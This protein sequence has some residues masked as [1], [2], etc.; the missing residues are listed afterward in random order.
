MRFYPVFLVSCLAFAPLCLGQ[1]RSPSP[2]PAATTS[3]AAAEA[4]K[5]VVHQLNNAFAR[6]FESVAP[7]VVIIE[8]SKKNDGS[9]PALDELFGGQPPDGN[10]V[11]GPR[12]DL[13]TQS[14]GSGFI[15][16]ADGYICTNY[17]VVEGADKIQVKLHDGREFEG[18]LVGNDEKTDIAVVKIEA[19]DLPVVRLGN[20]E[21]LRVGEFAFAIGAPF[22]LDYTFTYGVISGKGRSINMGG[23][24]IP[25]YIQTDASINPGTAAGPC[26]T[27]MAASSG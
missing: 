5:D 14:E 7:A 24:A 18:K 25:E 16:R 11:P 13:P 9:D 8:T 6:V 12:P 1:N 4:G 2:A 20:S 15:L 27:S 26:A 19:K 10:R 23:Y 22:K 21:A 3:A 17:H